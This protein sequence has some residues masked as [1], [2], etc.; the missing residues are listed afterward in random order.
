M[1]LSSA[2]QW[3]CFDA[4]NILQ[5][6][7]CLNTQIDSGATFQVVT[8]TYPDDASLID[9]AVRAM[10]ILIIQKSLDGF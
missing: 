6:D 7:A 10:L 4:S 3:P 9:V 1:G 8:Q 2:N 5:Y